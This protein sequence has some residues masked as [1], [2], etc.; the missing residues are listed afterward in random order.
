MKHAALVLLLSFPALAEDDLSV[1]DD[2][3]SDCADDCALRYGV[4]TR[5]TDRVKLGNC[6]NKCKSAGSDCRNRFFETRNNGLEQG[7]LKKDKHD[8]DLREDNRRRRVEDDP[9]P[10]ASAKSSDA[11]PVKKTREDDTPKRTATRAADLDT[12]AKKTD[13]KSADPRSDLKFE[14]APEKKEEPK[15]KESKLDSD[16]RQED[17]A[18]APRKKESSSDSAPAKKKKDRALDEWDPEAL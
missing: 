6:I 13:E 3:Y 16:V 2:R 5:D 9:A 10:K 4:T 15:A 18:P 8:D 1:C 11:P 14:P 12:N 7:A 17:T